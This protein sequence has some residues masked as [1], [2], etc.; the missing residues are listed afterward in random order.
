MKDF[1]KIPVSFPMKVGFIGFESDTFTLQR[2]GWSIACEKVLDPTRFNVGVRISLFHPGLRQYAI[3]SPVDIERNM[4]I[5]RTHDMR[6]LRN[7]L[8]TIKFNVVQFAS[9]FKIRVLAETSPFNFMAV[10][11]TP[12]WIEPKEYMMSELGIFKALAITPEQQ[13]Y[14]PENT[15]DELLTMIRKKQEPMQDEIRERARLAKSR[16]KLNESASFEPER[17]IRAQI[18]SFKRE[19]A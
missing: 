19:A 16:E 13:I 6:E 7:Y 8:E 14:V 9:D 4:R 11:A 2:N 18:L 3:T 5:I 15:V 10:D 17:N 1:D 12:Q